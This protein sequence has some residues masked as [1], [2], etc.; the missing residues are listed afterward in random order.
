MAIDLPSFSLLNIPY[1]P[2]P[3]LSSASRRLPPVVKGHRLDVVIVQAST[4]LLH[5]LPESVWQKPKP[6]CG[7]RDIRSPGPNLAGSS[8]FRV[9]S[10]ERSLK[11]VRRAGFV[12]SDIGS[13]FCWHSISTKKMHKEQ[14]RAC[15][16]CPGSSGLVAAA[17]GASGTTW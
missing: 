16:P 7:G 9:F 6:P 3:F 1:T 12:A 17:D 2:C 10:D 8:V 15:L 11:A 14:A 4:S 13:T 5:Y